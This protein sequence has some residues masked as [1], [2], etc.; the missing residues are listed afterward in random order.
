M[1]RGMAASRGVVF[2]FKTSEYKYETTPASTL[3]APPAGE[4]PQPADD[5][6][7]RR[8]RAADEEDGVVA[9]DR[10]EDVGPALPVERR[11]DRLGAAGDGAENDELADAVHGREELREEGVERRRAPAVGRRR[12]G[13]LGGR[14]AR[15]VLGRHAHETQLAQVARERRLRHVPAALPEEATQLLLA[16][17]LVGAH[18][19]ENRRLTVAF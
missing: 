6:V 9:A 15:A 8:R 10:P 1:V 5:A 17:H 2:V 12:G 13:A 3:G 19:L 18:E 7:A 11:R 16:P 14:V 4:R